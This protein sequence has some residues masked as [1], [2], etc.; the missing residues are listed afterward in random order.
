MFFQFHFSWC[1]KL[2]V[3]LYWYPLV[4]DVNRDDELKL[5]CSLLVTSRIEQ[6]LNQVGIAAVIQFFGIKCDV[7]VD[8]AYVR[9]FHVGHQQI[10][11]PT[12]Y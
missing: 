8:A 5:L 7:D 3:H 9:W 11:N 12:S 2:D 10:W 6:Q 4:A 1:K